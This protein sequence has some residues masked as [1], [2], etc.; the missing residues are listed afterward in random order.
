MPEGLFSNVTDGNLKRGSSAT[1]C[2]PEH[3]ELHSLGPIL[4]C[5]M[6]LLSTQ[7]VAA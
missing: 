2:D 6:L 3:L 5:D 7:E 4:V 1:E